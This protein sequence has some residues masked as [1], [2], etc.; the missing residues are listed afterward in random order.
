MDRQRNRWIPYEYFIS[1]ALDAETIWIPRGI[2]IYVNTSGLSLN[3]SYSCVLMLKQAGSIML[4][5][6][7]TSFISPSAHY[8]NIT[9]LKQI[10]WGH[11][12]MVIKK[13][14]IFAL[15]IRP[16]ISFRNPSLVLDKSKDRE[17]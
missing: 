10:Q 15:A 11:I 2:V 13:Y 12:F 5:D 17:L 7:A 9:L 3:S 14:I 16:K 6:E 4:T 8:L 1:P